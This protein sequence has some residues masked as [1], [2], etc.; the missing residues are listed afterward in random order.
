MGIAAAGETCGLRAYPK[1]VTQA[2]VEVAPPRRASA[3]LRPSRGEAAGVT[4]RYD[5]GGRGDDMADALIRIIVMTKYEQ[6][7]CTI[8]WR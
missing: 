5:D 4:L 1:P 7:R 3:A 2:E 8:V 6:G